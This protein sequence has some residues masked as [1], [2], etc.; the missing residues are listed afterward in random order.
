MLP[1]GEDALLVRFAL[2]ADPVAMQAAARLARRLEARPPPG[3]VEIVPALVSVL[4]RF[5]PARTGRCELAA[6]ALTL[7]EGCAGAGGDDADPARRWTIPLAFGG[8]NGPQLAEVA[9]M[10]GLSQ[11]AAI[12]QIC[13]PGLR[14]LAIGF[15]PGQPYIG[16]LPPSWDLPR[17]AALN[18]SVPAGAVV[19]AVRQIVI[20]GTASATGWRQVAR[21]AFRSFQPGRE[22]P[23]PLRAGDGIRL[24]PAA[25]AEI[26]ALAKGPD[27]LGG[28][29][30]EVLR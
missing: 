11:E 22:P 26:E 9:R 28:A 8:E 23:M 30:L 27:G 25:P 12:R 1:A 10:A 19:V 21:G 17:M 18:P 14:V 13:A 5:D 20:F 3:V 2:R 15:A 16:L 7:A 29:R 4:L 6:T 24:A